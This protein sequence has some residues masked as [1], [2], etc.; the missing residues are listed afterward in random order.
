M[1][2]EIITA[3]LIS[4][5]AAI[6]SALIGASRKGRHKENPNVFVIMDDG[7]DGK[8]ES[9]LRRYAKKTFGYLAVVIFYIIFG[10]A[11]AIAGDQY[12]GTDIAWIG[13]IIGLIVAFFAVR[14]VRKLI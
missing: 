1:P 8:E 5:L 10:V 3:A 4:A 13:L 7:K 14:I 12:L 9:R 11:G 2:S 6:I